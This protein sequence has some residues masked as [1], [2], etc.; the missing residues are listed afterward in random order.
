MLKYGCNPHQAASIRLPNPAPFRVM[1]GR[2]VAEQTDAVRG[3]VV[4]SL[5]GISHQHHPE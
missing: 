4:A 3:E 2:L 5:R 1:N